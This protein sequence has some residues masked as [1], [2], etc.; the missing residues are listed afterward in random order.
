MKKIL[1]A[2]FLLTGKAFFLSAQE[3]SSLN[4]KEN[5]F[6]FGEIAEEEG[7]VYHSFSFENTSKDTLWIESA[8]GHCHCTSAE[9]PVEGIPPKGK[10]IIRVMYDPKGRPWPFDAGLDVSLKGSKEKISLHLDG[11]VSRN[12]KLPRFA[13]A[14]FIQ[15]FDFNEKA[16]ETGE[17][18]FRKFV[19]SLLP[20]L[21]RHGDVKIKVES[22]ASKVPTKSYAGNEELTKARAASARAEILRIIKAA[23]AKEGRLQFLP[24]DNKVQGPEFQ[25]DYQKNP[26]KYAPFQYVKIRVF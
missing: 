24:D 19:E 14:E 22:S 21:E 11:N 16:I 1:L 9:F 10:G 17:K 23:G 6:S 26:A 7:I 4:F 18:E 2:F 3:K 20:L 12:K 25:Q 15:K 5:R 8:R 13:P